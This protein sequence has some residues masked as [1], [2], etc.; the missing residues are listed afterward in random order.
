MDSLPNKYEEAEAL[1]AQCLLSMASEPFAVGASPPTNN[2]SLQLLTGRTRRAPKRGASSGARGSS[3]S[4]SA[5]K[6]RHKTLSDSVLIYSHCLIPSQLFILLF[7]LTIAARR[8]KKKTS[9]NENS[10]VVAQKNK[11]TRKSNRK[12]AKDA[13]TVSNSQC[14]IIYLFICIIFIS[15]G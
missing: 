4:A 6:F 9:T 13:N 14:F 1:V 3:S 8:T 10:M 12:A 5:G 2:S 7:V 15:N 11:P